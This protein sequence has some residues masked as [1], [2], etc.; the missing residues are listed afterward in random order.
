MENKQLESSS[1]YKD[2]FYIQKI[3]NKAVNFVLERNKKK[4][5]DSVFSR[6]GKIFYKLPSGE[7]TEKSPFKN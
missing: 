5:I 1:V 4:N 7:I 2:A 6:D 3:G